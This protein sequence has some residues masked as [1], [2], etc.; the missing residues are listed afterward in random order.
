MTENTQPSKLSLWRLQRRIERNK[1][2]QMLYQGT[3]GLDYI[4]SHYLLIP[5]WCNKGDSHD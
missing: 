3:G 5:P 1:F 2:T 4:Q